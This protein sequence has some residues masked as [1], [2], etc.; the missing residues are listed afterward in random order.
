MSVTHKHCY[1]LLL[2]YDGGVFSGFQRQAPLPTVQESLENALAA[3]GVDVQIEG[4]GRTDSGVHARGQVATF[5]TGVQLDPQ[6]LPGILARHLPR[7]LAIRRAVAP[8]WSFHARFSA[9]AKE[10]RYRVTTGPEPT[11]WES[12]FTWTLPDLRGFPEVETVDRLDE[13]ALRATLT[14]LEGWHDFKSLAHPR[15]AG[16]T[17]RLLLH[18]GLEVTERPQG[19][20]RYEFTFR[21]P[22]FLRHQIRNMVGVAVTAGLGRLPDGLLAELLTGKGD[23][24]RGVRAPGR[25]LTLWAIRYPPADDPFPDE[26]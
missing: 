15:T 21:S 9:Q 24:W 16:K 22:G 18:G 14:A 11:P 1:A 8:G 19:G 20:A 6:A 26:R 13:T 3:V 10:Y 4:G 17:R 7:G 2:S 25:G 23:R 5:R 12:R